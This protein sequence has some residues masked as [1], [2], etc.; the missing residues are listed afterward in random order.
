MP[1]SIFLGISD[2]GATK[3]FCRFAARKSHTRR[4]TYLHSPP[5]LDY[6]LRSSTAHNRRDHNHH[7]QHNNHR[8]NV[9][10]STTRLHARLT[11]GPRKHSRQSLASGRLLRP[12]LAQRHTRP[13]PSQSPK[14]I[15][16]VPPFHC[17]SYAID[18]VAYSA[19]P[20][21]EQLLAVAEKD[22]IAGCRIKLLRVTKLLR[23]SFAFAIAI[24]FS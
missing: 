16:R 10:A 9:V 7:N 4:A 17:Y 8:H 21:K 13:R 23:Q 1:S 20:T 18:V 19:T 12:R 22:A 15:R 6:C 11:T 24:S 3:H 14:R 2:S 5:L